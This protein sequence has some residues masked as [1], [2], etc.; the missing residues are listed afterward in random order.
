MSNHLTLNSV[1]AKFSKWRKTRNSKAT[2]IPEELLAL[3]PPLRSHYKSYQISRTLGLSGTQLKQIIT[4]YSQANFIELPQLP[5]LTITSP[6]TNHITCE[7]FRIDG[8][9]LKI[10]TSELVL[11]S[12]VRQFLCCN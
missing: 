11:P 5:E 6:Q 9:S 7:F 2:K 8:A 1:A 10:S 3:V 4:K 12:L